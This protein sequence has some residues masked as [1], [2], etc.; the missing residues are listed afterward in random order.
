MREI[1]LRHPRLPAIARLLD[2]L[3]PSSSVAIEEALALA[4]RGRQGALSGICARPEMVPD[5]FSD[6]RALRRRHPI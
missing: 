6:G 3:P 5:P 1:H 2:D 4:S